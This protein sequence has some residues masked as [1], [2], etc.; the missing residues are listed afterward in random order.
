[1]S[2]E[3][4]QT[5]ERNET[6]LIGYT[7]MV[8]LNQDLEGGI[9]E[10]LREKLL[11]K[12]PELTNQLVDDGIYLIQVYSDAEW[13]PDVPFESIV[14]VEVRDFDH[15]PEGLVQH[16]L[17]AGQYVK[18]THNG[19]EAQIGET[20]DFIRDQDICPTRPFDFEY[21]TNIDA[22]NQKESTIDIYLPVEA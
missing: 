22:L 3:Q 14:A 10:Q 7:V 11:K 2:L 15:I 5:I 9:I 4:L 16:T 17:P 20:Y 6:K 13:T 21:W 12:R 18:V 19:P 8:S 1:M